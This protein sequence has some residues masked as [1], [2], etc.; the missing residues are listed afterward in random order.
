MTQLPFR[1]NFVSKFGH[2]H[3]FSAKFYVNFVSFRVVSKIATPTLHIQDGNIE[4]DREEWLTNLSASLLG[5]GKKSF[6]EAVSTCLGSGNLEM[7]RVC[8]ITVAWLS[9]AL[10][11]LPDADEFHLSS[12]S[13]LISPLKECLE[14]GERVEHRILASMS[15]LNFSKIPGQQFSHFINIFCELVKDEL[16]ILFLGVC[17]YLVC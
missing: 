6:L 17:K 14:N 16:D 13:A 3:K 12:F 8:L 10:A 5:D 9:S 1:A 11:S 15:L 4:E 2:K 7:V